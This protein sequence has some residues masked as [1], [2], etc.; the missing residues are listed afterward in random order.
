[1]N[2]IQKLGS[3]FLFLVLSP[4]L[5]TLAINHSEMKN[6]ITGYYQ[7]SLRSAATNVIGVDFPGLMRASQNYI[8]DIAKDPRLVAAVETAIRDKKGGSNQGIRDIITE[9]REDV[10]L[11]IM[12][13]P[14]MDGNMLFSSSAHRNTLNVSQLDLFHRVVKEGWAT[15]FVFDDIKKQ[16]MVLTGSLIKHQQTAIGMLLGGYILDAEK[17]K[18]LANH[19]DVFLI[20]QDELVKGQEGGGLAAIAGSNASYSAMQAVNMAE[21][22]ELFQ[23]VKVA[24]ERDVNSNNCQQPQIR[25]WTKEVANDLLIYAGVPVRLGQ[26]LPFG[27]LVIV[28]NANQ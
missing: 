18:E 1:M 24:C 2:L 23:S 17:L 6:S 8:K 4:M 13:V 19:G 3:G 27:S 16:Y 20:K 11:S 9:I 28:Q 12:E 10:A 5:A 14:G 7:D 21:M 26:S 25:L 15:M 22:N